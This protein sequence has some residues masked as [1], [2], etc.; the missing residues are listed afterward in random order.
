MDGRVKPGH[1]EQCGCALYAVWSA[2]PMTIFSPLP[3]S[4]IPKVVVERQG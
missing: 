2:L 1:D 4:D 3:A